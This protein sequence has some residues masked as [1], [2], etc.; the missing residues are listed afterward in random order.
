MDGRRGAGGGEGQHRPRDGAVLRRAALHAIQHD[1]LEDRRT[2][3]LEH[4]AAHARRR[5]S[6]GVLRSRDIPPLRRDVAA[7]GLGMSVAVA[8][9]FAGQASAKAYR[10]AGRRV[11]SKRLARAISPGARV[12]LGCGQNRLEGWL[13]V[14]L[15][16]SC[17]PDVLHDLRWGFPAP[18]AS[19][20]L[21]YSE[22]VLEHLAFDDG[23]R[24]LH[25]CRRALE[26]GGALRIAMPD[27]EHLVDRY[28]S[29]WRDQDWLTWPGYEWVDSPARMLNTAMRSWG[30]RYVYDR[31]ELKARL[32]EAGF[33]S[34]TAEQWGASS[35]AEFRDRE[36]RADS[37]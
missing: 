2:R 34:T 18:P 29:D 11:A 10:V 6:D 26:P 37:L 23:M 12:H 35:R 14:D 13:N 33:T 16:R 17:R 1:R 20:S 5:G 24:L 30:H 25:D 8:T 9:Q 28:R 15:V 3:R 36:T 32:E 7:R 19:V 27:L 31:A 22:H 21:I 4:V